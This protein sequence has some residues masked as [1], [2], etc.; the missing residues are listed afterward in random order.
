MAGLS[1]LASLTGPTL[2][3]PTAQPR[4]L[5]PPSGAPS[6]SRA[7]WTVVVSG[8]PRSGTSLLMQMLEAGGLPIVSDGR[9]AADADNPRG[10]YEHDAVR[11]LHRD[12]GWLAQ[13]I[14]GAV[15]IVSPLLRHLP[16][17]PRYRVVLIERD[18]DEVLAS[19][20]AML[21][22]RAETRGGDDDGSDDAPAETRLRGAFEAQRA[23]CRRWLAGRA[24]VESLAIQ[25]A[26]L[27]AEPRR[28]A[29]RLAAFVDAGL[30]IAAMTAV[31]DPTLHRQRAG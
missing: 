19:Q 6:P 31:V 10:Y 1:L 14:G 7:G 11:S 29:G 2:P 25:H 24:D 18:L 30:D 16:A 13:P 15:K 5:P 9:R 23:H 8:L 26:E 21:E 3:R 12:A 22:R 17:G 20:R 27:L 28:V 4:T